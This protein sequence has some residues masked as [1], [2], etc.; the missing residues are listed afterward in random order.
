MTETSDASGTPPEDR[1]PVAP[2]AAQVALRWSDMDAYA[3]IN[4]VQLVRMIVVYGLIV[5]CFFFV[6]G[7]V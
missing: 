4:N 3:H 7:G 6:G 5:L 1:P 2:Y